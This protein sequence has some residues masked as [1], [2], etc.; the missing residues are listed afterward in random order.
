MHGPNATLIRLVNAT[1]SRQWASTSEMKGGRVIP[2]AGNQGAAGRFHS[3]VISPV[4]TELTSRTRP[5]MSV[6]GGKAEV[7][8]RGDCGL[9]LE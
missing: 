1:G 2:K 6:P 4:G 3:G 9:L 8:F 5:K 7:T